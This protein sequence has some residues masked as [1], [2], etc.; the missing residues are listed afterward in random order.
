MNRFTSSPS[1]IDVPSF[2]LE[3]MKTQLKI[4]GSDRDAQLSGLLVLSADLIERYTWRLLTERTVKG[5]FNNATPSRA[6]NGDMLDC[7]RAP[8]FDDS[9]LSITFK[10][11]DSDEAL[12]GFITP[13]HEF[14]ECFITSEPEQSANDEAAYPVVV[15]FKAGYPVDNFGAWLC[16]LPLQQAIIALAMYIY[17]NPLD[18][19]AG[20][21]SCAGGVSNGVRLP[22]TVSMMLDSYVIRR[23]DHA[24]YL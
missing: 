4:I 1:S 11:V 13:V 5:E 9:L 16:P 2:L 14:G 23:Y 12:S 24:M 20:G 10:G 19:G 3:S 7:Q 15:Q 22:Q 21:C 18:C 17:A 6:T 8:V